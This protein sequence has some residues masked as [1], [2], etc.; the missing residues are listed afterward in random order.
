M[1]SSE[2][3][4]TIAYMNIRGQT[5]LEYSKQVQIE[6]FV[7]FYNIDILNCQEINI[8]ENSFENCNFINSWISLL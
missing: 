6:N 2:Q 1:A 7:K 4:L 3:I 5:G 8:L